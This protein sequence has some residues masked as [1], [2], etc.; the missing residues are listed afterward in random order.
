MERQ[1]VLDHPSSTDSSARSLHSLGRND[2][3]EMTSLRMTSGGSR[4]LGK[5][6][7]AIV[8]TTVLEGES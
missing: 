6:A 2:K 1:G 8:F 7:A 4:S 3:N 5:A